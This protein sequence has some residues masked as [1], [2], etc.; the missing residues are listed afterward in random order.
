MSSGR[1][2]HRSNKARPY[3][4]N[5]LRR[6]LVVEYLEDRTLMTVLPL[7]L[8]DPSF[9][10]NSAFGASSDPSMSADGQLVV[11]ETSAPNLVPNDVNGT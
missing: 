1:F 7:T 6:P 5:T 10:G 2:I 9:F 4:K 8:A 11:F 3:R